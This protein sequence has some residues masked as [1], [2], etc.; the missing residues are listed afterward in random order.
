VEL[1]GE[2]IVDGVDVG[3]GEEFLIATVGLRNIEGSGGGAG[4]VE[5]AR[6]DGVYRRELAELHGGEDFF[7]ADVCGAEYAPADFGGHDVM[8]KRVAGEARRELTHR[9]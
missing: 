9:G 6:G 5:A 8:I 2:R 4:G 1:V 3:V 7:Y